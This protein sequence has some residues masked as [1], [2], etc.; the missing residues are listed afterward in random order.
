MEEESPRTWFRMFSTTSIGGCEN[1][2]S[3]VAHRDSGDKELMSCRFIPSNTVFPRSVWAQ[4]SWW[5][6]QV[7]YPNLHFPKIENTQAFDQNRRLIYCVH[8]QIWAG[9]HSHLS[10]MTSHFLCP[11]LIRNLSTSRGK[12][13]LPI[14]SSALPSAQTILTRCHHLT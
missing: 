10:G 14:Q 1:M 13:D 6:H 8:C 7:E 9:S 4:S 5:P 3:G 2:P 11:H 12:K